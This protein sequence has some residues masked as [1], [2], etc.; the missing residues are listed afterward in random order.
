MLGVVADS[1]EVLASFESLL[2]YQE[3]SEVCKTF[4]QLWPQDFAITLIAG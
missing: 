2:K 3:G 4:L 1:I